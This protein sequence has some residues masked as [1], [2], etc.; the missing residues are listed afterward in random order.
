MFPIFPPAGQNIWRGHKKC[1]VRTNGRRGNFKS[2]RKLA[3]RRCGAD[4]NCEICESQK[5]RNF[6]A[7]KV[8]YY[9][10]V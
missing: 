8:G 7:A 9:G 2:T 6:C 1:L 5:T 3:A 4:E 10:D